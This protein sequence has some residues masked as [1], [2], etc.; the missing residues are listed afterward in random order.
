MEKQ[1][2]FNRIFICIRI[3]VYILIIYVTRNLINNNTRFVCFWNEKYGILCPSCGAT[4]ATLSILKGDILKAFNYNLVYTVSILPL[5]FGF[6]LE[7]ILM[8]LLR[9]FKLT[10]ARS[11]LETLFE[12]EEATNECVCD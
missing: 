12:I 8:I 9:I 3:V 1:I 6:L 11:L 2:W 7:D 10:K 5:A 4:R